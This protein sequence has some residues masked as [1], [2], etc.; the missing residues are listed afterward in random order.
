VQLDGQQPFQ[1]QMGHRVPRHL[2]ATLQQGMTLK[3][4]VDPANPTQ[5][6]AID[7][8]EG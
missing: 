8:G 2:E 7:W 1:A 4:A 3:V 5:S 6:V